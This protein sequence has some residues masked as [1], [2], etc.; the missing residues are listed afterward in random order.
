MEASWLLLLTP[1]VSRVSVRADLTR[2]PEI[3]TFAGEVSLSQSVRSL[4]S[5]P[6]RDRLT[7]PP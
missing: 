1:G 7:A 3:Y 2:R 6:V 4:L 5:Q